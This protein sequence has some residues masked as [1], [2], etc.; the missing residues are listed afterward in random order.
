MRLKIPRIAKLDLRRPTTQDPFG[1]VGSFPPP[2]KMSRRSTARRG[3]AGA[4]AR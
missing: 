4:G 3:S 2:P 1:W